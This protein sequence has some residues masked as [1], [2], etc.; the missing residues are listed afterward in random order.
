MGLGNGDCFP[1]L[2]CTH[3]MPEVSKLPAAFCYSSRHELKKAEKGLTHVLRGTIG[4][5]GS[6]LANK[7]KADSCGQTSWDSAETDVMGSCG[8]ASHSQSQGPAQPHGPTS[9][10]RLRRGQ[11]PS[12]H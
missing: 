11:P 12:G 5:P 7:N 3:D 9:Q 6:S 10:Q 1:P 2:N 8:N 4:Y